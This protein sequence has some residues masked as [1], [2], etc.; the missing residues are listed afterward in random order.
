MWT[1]DPTRGPCRGGDPTRGLCGGGDPTRG[2]GVG[3]DPTRGPCVGGDPTRGPCVGGDPTRGLCVGG[4][5][6]RCLCVGGDPTRGP[7]GGGYTPQWRHHTGCT[8]S[9][10]SA[11]VVT[12][13][14]RKVTDKSADSH[15][16]GLLHSF[17]PRLFPLSPL[18]TWIQ[19]HISAIP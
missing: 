3:G 9:C 5:P 4:D 18:S 19:R 13:Q 11:P 14:D 1:G 16:G 7:C 8:A 17:P 12:L 10:S 2:P 6:T 15:T